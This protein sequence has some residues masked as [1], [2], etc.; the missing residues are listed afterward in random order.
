[1]KKIAIPLFLLLIIGCSREPLD[2]TVYVIRGD[3]DIT[4]AAAVQVYVLPFGTISEFK[5]AL[6]AEEKKLDDFYIETTQSEI[7]SSFAPSK[8]DKLSQKRDMV[9]RFSKG[10]LQQ[11]KSAS[12]MLDPESVKV[13]INEEQARLNKLVEKE[14]AEKKQLNASQIKITYDY[15]S[16]EFGMVT[17]SNHSP[18]KVTSGKILGGFVGGL[19]ILG[20]EEEGRLELDPGE[21]KARDLGKCYRGDKG[22]GRDELE[23]R[24]GRVCK[25]N[26]YFD[27]Y[28]LEEFGPVDYDFDKGHFLG[29]WNFWSR[30][31]VT[32][33]YEKMNYRL[34]AKQAIG[35]GKVESLKTELK[36]SEQANSD[37]LICNSL[38][39]EIAAIESLD[40]PA[41]GSD[42]L[43][44]EV[45]RSDAL[46]LGF[47]VQ[48]LYARH[49]ETIQAF[50]KKSAI[51]QTSTDIN[52]RFEFKTPPNETF[53]IYT[54]YED[55]FINME[56]IVPITKDDKTIELNN[57]SA[58]SK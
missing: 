55:S 42:R 33:N 8:M 48:T 32:L 38:T 13:Q 26:E 21:E 20:C 43:A 50:A 46:A 30:T 51:A 17:I 22:R 47:V 23:R 40:C 1:M 27:A 4:R 16:S 9:S 36:K 3:G 37:L 41:P 6:L 54:S 57:S 45:F 35:P 15:D 31:G 56:W 11:Q 5:S 29:E 28:C 14:I 24:G 52:G 39:S 34:L 10:C 25:K 53:L 49:L 58:N 44:L 2:G 19:Y 12:E 18:Y 7:C